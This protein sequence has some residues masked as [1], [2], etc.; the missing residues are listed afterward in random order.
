MNYG[1]IYKH[2]SC[3]LVLSINTLC[4]RYIQFFILKAAQGQK[5]TFNSK[6]LVFQEII[7]VLVVGGK[8]S[9]FF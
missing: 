3:V 1:E 4:P 2:F 7:C 5:Q 9:L 6:T 8:S